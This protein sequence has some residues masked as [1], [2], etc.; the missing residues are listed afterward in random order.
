MEQESHQAHRK[1]ACKHIV[2]QIVCSHQKQFEVATTAIR[3]ALHS[4]T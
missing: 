2:S 1:A 4:E 3:T